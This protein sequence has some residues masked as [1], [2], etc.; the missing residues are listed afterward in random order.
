MGYGSLDVV[1]PG[2]AAQSKLKAKIMQFARR[3]L[4]LSEIAGGLTL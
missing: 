2:V 4:N 3:S 1:Q